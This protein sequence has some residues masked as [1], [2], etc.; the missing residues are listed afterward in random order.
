MLSRRPNKTDSVGVLRHR[1]VVS[2][3]SFTE[4]GTNPVQFGA[5]V[6]YWSSSHRAEESS[7]Q[8][9]WTSR[10]CHRRGRGTGG[11]ALMRV[12]GYVRV[13]TD[14]QGA[15]SSTSIA[16]SRFSSIRREHGSPTTT[17]NRSSSAGLSSALVGAVTWTMCSRIHGAADDPTPS[18]IGL[19]CCHRLT[20]TARASPPL[21]MRSRARTMSS[22]RPISP[23]E[24]RLRERRTSHISSTKRRS[25][26]LL[27]RARTTSPPRYR[28]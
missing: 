10:G 18:P 27:P 19:P 4:A 24:A 2:Y 22:H 28:A 3:T 5:K 7:R 15:S 20:P 12:L 25:F 1:D 16:S 11:L 8:T 17:T 26:R 13:S 6:R 14:E 9:G 21:P 23:K